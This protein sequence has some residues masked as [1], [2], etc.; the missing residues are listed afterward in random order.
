M[1]TEDQLTTW[2]G[3]F[4]IYLYFGDLIDG[5]QVLEVGCKTGEGADFLV[6]CGADK[7]LAVD[8]RKPCIEHAEKNYASAKITFLHVE[9]SALE[10]LDN[11]IDTAFVADGISVLRNPEALAE[12]RRVLRPNG[13]L[14]IRTQNG[15]VER[16]AHKG[17]TYY[18]F[19][20]RLTPSFENI[21]MFAES[22]FLGTSL[23]EYGDEDAPEPDESLDTSLEFLG[24]GVSSS[25]Y[26]CL[27]GGEAKEALRGL[28]VVRFPSSEGLDSLAKKVDSN[29]RNRVEKS[30]RR[31]RESNPASAKLAVADKEPNA[32][33]Q[34][35]AATEAAKNAR[36]IAELKRQLDEAQQELGRVVAGVG[37]EMAKAK[38]ESTTL[39]R[40]VLELE[41]EIARTEQAALLA[42]AAEVNPLKSDARNN[43]G[44]A[45]DGTN[46][47]AKALDAGEIDLNDSL[48]VLSEESLEEF[49]SVA[50][51]GEIPFERDTSGSESFGVAQANDQQADE[52]QASNGPSATEQIAEA[53]SAHLAELAEVQTALEESQAWCKELEGLLAAAEDS[54]AEFKA[55]KRAAEAK[56]DE[57]GRELSQWR[58]RASTAEGLALKFD[59]THG[60]AR[61]EELEAE[62]LS[63]KTRSQ[64]QRT[65]ALRQIDELETALREQAQAISQSDIEKIRRQKRE[66]LSVQVQELQEKLAE[67]PAGVEGTHPG[68]AAV[69]SGMEGQLHSA[70]SLLEHLENGLS[71]IRSQR[72]LL[73]SQENRSQWSSQREQAISEMASE[74]GMKDAEITLLSAGVSAL[75]KRLADLEE[76]LNPNAD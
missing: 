7:V 71:D 33:A 70:T 43:A 11:S 64:E 13:H 18:E 62:L 61:I 38:A 25:E 52:Q 9:L 56:V 72:D 49:S 2:L 6:N 26:I 48:E 4:P 10:L 15:D 8:V 5:K 44:D 19:E 68:V 24:K 73:P 22:P 41:A 36:E 47:E 27:A 17:A 29:L 21:R 63:V 35:L 32:A 50:D 12:I 69:I 14:I 65:E 67:Q 59:K 51:T 57:R 28:T 54:T 1:S 75:Q 46:S 20:E 45:D 37:V 39:R 30:E 66:S 76:R 23:V 74:L 16:H 58:T 42:I 31:A 55:A 3:A 53:L 34:A 60:Q 40:R